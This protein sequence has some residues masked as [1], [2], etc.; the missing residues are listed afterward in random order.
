MTSDQDYTHRIEAWRAERLARLMAEDGWLN[1]IGRWWLEQPSIAIGA[2]DDNDV[3]LPVGPAYAGTLAREAGGT[4]VFRPADGGAPMR[5]TPDKKQP[6]TF[7]GRPVA[8][9]GD[10]T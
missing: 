2:A 7:H 10:H 4:I 3:V 6:V 8:F 9:G 5:L 1:I